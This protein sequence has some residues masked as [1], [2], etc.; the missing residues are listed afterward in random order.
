MLASCASAKKSSAQRTVQLVSIQSTELAKIELANGAGFA[1]E[2]AA[3]ASPKQT[4]ANDVSTIQAHDQID[5]PKAQVLQQQTS[6]AK[7]ERQHTEEASAATVR[8]LD[9]LVLAWSK[10][11]YWIRQVQLLKATNAQLTADNTVLRAATKPK[12]TAVPKCVGSDTTVL[13]LG[14]SRPIPGKPWHYS[15]NVTMRPCTAEAATVN[16]RCCRLERMKDPW[17]LRLTHVLSEYEACRLVSAPPTTD[18]E[19]FDPQIGFSTTDQ[20]RRSF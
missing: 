6:V 8:R 12:H 2:H 19:V 20:G 18:E 15:V 7:L 14:A 17:D 5:R 10:V 13:L 11:C 1:H 9:D 4:S 3:R 16:G